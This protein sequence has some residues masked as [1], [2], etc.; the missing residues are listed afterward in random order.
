MELIS[1]KV[2]GYLTIMLTIIL[3][4]HVRLAATHSQ[5]L[6]PAL[7][8]TQDAPPEYWRKEKV[9]TRT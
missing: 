4:K 5:S 6:D 1:G 2:K 7:L 9:K 3:A 8:P